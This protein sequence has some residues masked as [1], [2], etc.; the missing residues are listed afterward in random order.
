[1]TKTQLFFLASKLP[2]PNAATGRPAYSNLDLLPGILRVLRS[3]CRWRDL[4]LP[5][6]PSAITHWRRLRFWRRT[7]STRSLWEELLALLAASNRLDC[8]RLA[9]DGTLVPSYEFSDRTGF[10]GKHGATGMKVSL[11]VDADGLP[12]GIS[13]AQG[14]VHDQA[15]A[16]LTVWHMRTPYR[17]RGTLNADRGYDGFGVRTFLKH[18]GLQPNIPARRGTHVR[19]GFEE[20][21]R[22]DKALGRQRYVIERTNGRLKSFRRLHFRFDRTSASFEAFLWL[23]VLVLCVRRLMV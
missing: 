13:L 17:P 7:Q 10:S 21:Y 14:W 18:L 3:G 5:G 22:Y 2:E 8:S 23:A 9:L 15:L 12:L 1:M 20:V 19:A 4:D 16:R 11:I 6:Y